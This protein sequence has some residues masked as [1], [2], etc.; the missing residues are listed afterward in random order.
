MPL[1]GSYFVDI[2]QNLSFSITTVSFGARD[3]GSYDSYQGTGNRFPN[4]VASPIPHKPPS[5]PHLQPSQPVEV[6]RQ[7][8]R[9]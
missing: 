6:L 5:P 4:Y 1:E 3:F 2:K 7:L 8:L 9:P